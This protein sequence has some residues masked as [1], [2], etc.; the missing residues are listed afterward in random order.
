MPG[1]AEKVQSLVDNAV[2][3]GAKVRSLGLHPNQG[4]SLRLWGD[5]VGCLEQ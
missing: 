2:A 5:V 4:S 3:K 1:L